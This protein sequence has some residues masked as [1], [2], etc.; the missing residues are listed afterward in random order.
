MKKIH[1]ILDSINDL[2]PIP[3]VAQK[4]MFL[5]S[6]PDSSL[7]E[8]S[9]VITYDQGATATLLRLCNSA[10][11]GLARKIDSVHQAVVFLGMTQVVDLV[12]MMAAAANLKPEQKGYDLGENDLWRYSVSSALLARE[13]AEKLGSKENHLVFTAGLLKDIGKVVL[14]QY[15]ADEAKEIEN[16]VSEQGMSFGEAEKRVIGIDHAELGGRIAR[17]W[18]FSPRMVNIIRNHHLTRTGPGTDLETSIVYLADVMCMMMGIGVGCD[19]LAYKFD[20]E[21]IERLDISQGEIMEIM[22]GFGEKLE[23]VEEFVKA[24]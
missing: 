9:E 19:G 6:N 22:A 11:F 17:K 7:S 5:A 21:I 23:Q 10:H 13:L 12:L 8:L 18:Q 24:F 4:V 15:V 20:E 1:K 16:L 2:K 14:N 3:Q